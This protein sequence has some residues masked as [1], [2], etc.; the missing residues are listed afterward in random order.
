MGDTSRS[1]SSASE[2][3]RPYRFRLDVSTYAVRSGT[4]TLLSS[5][6]EAGWVQDF[7]GSVP[8]QGL[9]VSSVATSEGQ[10]MD[11]FKG[12]ITGRCNRDSHRVLG[13][14]M[15]HRA[16]RCWHRRSLA[17]LL[18]GIRRRK[19]FVRN[20]SHLRAPRRQRTGRG[21]GPCSAAPWLDSRCR[22]SGTRPRRTRSPT[23]ST[24][25]L[26]PW[27]WRFGGSGRVRKPLRECAPP[28]ARIAWLSENRAVAQRSAPTRVRPRLHRGN[29]PHPHVP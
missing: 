3:H 29:A 14:C 16:A 28:P 19:V 8:I 12:G 4:G 1:G 21:I 20:G 11:R 27:G 13:M 6:T 2:G 22:S 23:A 5:R 18:P 10:R 15:S 17:A 25:A 7:M 26:G 9:T 24:R